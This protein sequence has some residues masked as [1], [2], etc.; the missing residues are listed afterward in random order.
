M[1]KEKYEAYRDVYSFLHY[2]YDATK[3]TKEQVIKDIKAYCIK[4]AEEQK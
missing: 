4:K 3:K 1:T 2:E